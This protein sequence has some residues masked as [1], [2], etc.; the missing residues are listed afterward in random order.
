METNTVIN[1]ATNEMAFE[2]IF[3]SFHT[4]KGSAGFAGLPGMYN[5]FNSITDHLRPIRNG[6]KALDGAIIS[7]LPS[8]S[9]IVK[10]LFENFEKGIELAKEDSVKILRDLGIFQ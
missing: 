4:L 7:K 6:E 1:E 10:K 3:R 9:V 5:V 2:T 8:Y